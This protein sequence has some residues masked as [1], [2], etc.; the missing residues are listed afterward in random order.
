MKRPDRRF[1]HTRLGRILTSAGALGVATALGTTGLGAGAFTA[2]ASAAA[3]HTLHLAYTNVDQSP[4]PAIFYGGIGDD[5]ELGL[6]EGLTTYGQNS[7]KLLPSLAKSWT[8]SPD[9]LTYTFHLQPDV[10]FHDGTPWNSAAAKYSWQ[11]DIKIANAPEYMLSDIQSM[12]TPGPLTFVVHMKKPNSAFLSYQASPFGPKF[13]SPTTVKAHLG[14]DNGQSWLATHDAGTGPYVLKSLS[15]TAG[16]V[17]QAYPKYWG[18]KPYYTTVDISI[19]P[20][21]TTEELELEHGQ[22]DLISNGLNATDLAKLASEHKYNIQVFPDF[23]EMYVSINPSRDNI[24]SD[25]AIRLALQQAIDKKLVIRQTYGKAGTQ[26]NAFYPAKELPGGMGDDTLGYHPSVL[27]KLLGKTHLSKNIVIMEQAGGTVQNE[28][29][30]LVQAELQAAGVHATL[31]VYPPA[32]ASALAQHPNQQPDIKVGAAFPDTSSP[33][34][35]ATTYIMKTAPLNQT[36]VNVPAG[37]ADINRGQAATTTAKQNFY[38][39]R[40]AQEYMASGQVFPIGE[41]NSVV[42]ARSGIGHIVHNISDPT[43]IVLSQLSPG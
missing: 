36:S 34:A 18:H 20:N 1:R 2:E 29:A 10:T 41:V 42:V 16:Y 24:L 7:S 43:G 13:V 37:D 22:I 21:E 30:E 6:Y 9:G 17:L 12:D 31:R 11:R 33:A 4:D 32:V 26:E 40:A 14:K 15:P 28:V 23:D 8:I 27:P 25:R 3:S 5:V 19:V 35:W 38:F 39:A